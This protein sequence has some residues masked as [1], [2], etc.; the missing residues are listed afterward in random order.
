LAGSTARLFLGVKIECAQCHKHP[1][2]DWTRTQFWEFAAFFINVNPNGGLAVPVAEDEKDQ[3][4][5]KV[6]QPPQSV[7]PQI[8][9]PKTDPPQFVKAKFLDGSAPKWQ[10]GMEPRKVLAGWVTA[11][12]NPYFARIAVN[13]MWHYFFGTG[14]VD[15]YDDFGEHNPA[16]HPELLDELAD[17]FVQNGYDLKYLARAI[18]N[19]KTYQLSSTPLVQRKKDE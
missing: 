3:P 15:P 5:A 18:V 4:P 12:D 14:L 7:E 17:Q 11:R 19:S 1:F 6:A 8:Q 16:S 2:A 13:Q 10:G 9:I